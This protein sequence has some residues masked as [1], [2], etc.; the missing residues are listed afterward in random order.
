[1]PDK[2]KKLKIKIYDLHDAVNI[3]QSKIAF[4]TEY[5]LQRSLTEQNIIDT[6]SKKD[7]SEKDNSLG[8]EYLF[9]ISIHGEFVL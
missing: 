5:N 3:S 6:K 7:T 9:E 4:I 8:K 2:I 1:M